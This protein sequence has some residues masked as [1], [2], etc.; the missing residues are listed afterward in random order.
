MSAKNEI[1]KFASA[2]GS[3]GFGGV[4]LAALCGAIPA[5]PLAVGGITLAAGFLSGASFVNWGAQDAIGLLEDEKLELGAELEIAKNKLTILERDLLEQLAEVKAERDRHIAELDKTKLEIKDEILRLKKSIKYWED[6][7]NPD[8]LE[9]PPVKQLVETLRNKL[10]ENTKK[11]DDTLAALAHQKQVN[12]GLVVTIDELEQANEDLDAQLANT[13]LELDKLKQNFNYK[14]EV[15]LNRAIEPRLSK[16]VER[17]IGRKLAE[18]ANLKKAIGMLQSELDNKDAVMQLLER[19][20]LPEIE[21]AYNNELS[22][23][24]QELLR[25]SGENDVL[26]RQLAKYNEPRHFAGYTYPDQVGNQIIDHFFN[27]GVIFDAHCTELV[28]DGYT[29][30]FKIDRNPDQTKLS[31]EEINKLTNQVGLMGLSRKELKFELHPNDFLVSVN[32]YPGSFESPRLGADLAAK[33]DRNLSTVN[34]NFSDGLINLK[35]AK[36]PTD[37]GK[38]APSPIDKH[39]QRFVDLD[40]YPK[41]QFAELVKRRIKE[42]ARIIAGSAGGKS[43]LNEIYSLTTAKMFAQTRKNGA[44]VYFPNPLPGGDKDWFTTP[45]I[46]K[47]GEGGVAKVAECLE[48]LLEEVLRRCAS[49]AESD[50]WPYIH[51]MLDEGNMIARYFSRQGELIKQILQAGSHAYVGLGASGQGLEITGWSGGGGSPANTLRANDF[52]VG[53]AHILIDEAALLWINKYFVGQEREDLREQY[54]KLAELCEELNEQEGLINKPNTGDERIVSPNAYRFAF[55]TVPAGK[56]FFF[57][58]PSYGSV[59]IEGLSFP[60]GAEVTS[61]YHNAEQDK[62]DQNSDRTTDA[63]FAACPYCLST[64]FKQMEPYKDGR[65]RYVCGSRKCRKK[66]SL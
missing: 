24:D 66:F 29:L 52:I 22:A 30:K 2:I 56:P 18:I 32:I 4:G 65:S 31:T 41:D 58:I 59:S 44:I 14:L 26:K 47:S 8:I 54:Y 50:E 36:T 43:P 20:K 27:H 35:T 7:K 3:L 45:S 9:V 64:N 46:V 16:A 63:V 11:L 21:T 37:K 12:E 33:S 19:E 42:R 57:Q 39:R 38:S 25:L 23:R 28:I 34:G 17:A 55:C 49:G 62:I 61:R 6:G 53:A 10:A 40:C 51:L 48:E 13:L 5:A 60:E 1:A 15:E